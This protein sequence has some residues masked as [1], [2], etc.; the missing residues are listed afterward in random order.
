VAADAQAFYELT[1]D[2]LARDPGSPRA[3]LPDPRARTL[4]G[5]RVRRRLPANATMG[6]IIDGSGDCPGTISRD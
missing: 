3:G 4:T 1:V 2:A 5:G 6:Q